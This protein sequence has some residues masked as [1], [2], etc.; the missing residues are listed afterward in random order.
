MNEQSNQ[1]GSDL[2]RKVVLVGAD[3]T[4]A[5]TSED[6]LLAEALRRRHAS[7]AFAGWDDPAIDWN[8]SDR[9]VIRSPWTV[10]RSGRRPEFLAWARS[11]A[12]HT[13]VLPHPTVL[14]WNTHKG[15]LENLAA[16]GVRVVPT[17]IIVRGGAEADNVGSGTHV[18]KPAVGCSGHGARILE[19]PRDR[20]ELTSMATEADVALQP[21][22]PAISVSGERSVIVIDG[23]A[24][25]AVVKHP[26]VGDFRVQRHFGGR[27]EALELTPAMASHAEQLVALAVER[28]GAPIPWAR[29]DELMDDHG[30]TELIELETSDPWLHLERSVEATAR[31]A[32][33]ILA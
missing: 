4:A 7:V 11:V 21:F 22:R 30:H 33:T 10:Y 23:R 19:L 26:A 29:V 5:G 20:D 1:G 14:D 27:V 8:E 18:A 16:A 28:F 3:D 25:H 6:E 32:A 17:S 2:P 15:Y 31:M 9:V 12:A 24:T 13:V